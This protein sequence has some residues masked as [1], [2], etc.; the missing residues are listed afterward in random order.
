MLTALSE[1]PRGSNGSQ[2][3]PPPPQVWQDLDFAFAVGILGQY[4][5]RAMIAL[6]PSQEIRSQFFLLTLFST[7]PVFYVYFNPIKLIG[8]FLEGGNIVFLY[9]IRFWRYQFIINTYRLHNS[10]GKCFKEG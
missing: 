8:T 5:P 6:S 3:P 4:L 1:G 10:I 9:P 2:A 7:I